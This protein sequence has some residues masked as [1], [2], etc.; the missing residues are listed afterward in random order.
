MRFMYKRIPNDE[1]KSHFNMVQD[2]VNSIYFILLDLLFYGLFLL[3]FT[4]F[5]SRSILLSILIFI[6]FYL[7][8]LSIYFLLKKWLKDKP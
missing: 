4:L 5:A 7:F 2:V 3:M 6:G 1:L 8:G